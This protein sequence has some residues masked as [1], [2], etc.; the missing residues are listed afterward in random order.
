MLTLQQMI[1][2]VITDADGSAKEKLAAEAEKKEEKRTKEQIERQ[3]DREEAQQGGGSPDGYAEKTASAYVESLAAAVEEVNQALFP[4]LAMPMSEA[5]SSVG[6]G[7]GPGATST[8]LESPVP[9][10]Q[11][12]GSGQ[13]RT[14]QIPMSPPMESKGSGGND[15][16]PANAMATNAEMMHGE[17]PE[18]GVL[19]QGSVAEYL[20][21]IAKEAKGGANQSAFRRA[22]RTVGN[23]GR[24]DSGGLLQSS[25]GRIPGVSG[26]AGSDL[27]DEAVRRGIKRTVGGTAVLGTLGTAAAARK[28][29]GGKVL[30]PVGIEDRSKA[31]KDK[32]AEDRI[33]P[34][35]ISAPKSSALPEDAPSTMKRPAEV[36]SQEKW[37][38]NNE[39]PVSMGKSD[40]KGV[41]K[42]RMGEV[43]SE[44]A[45]SAS[46]D[47]VLDNALGA[48]TVDQAKAKIA[49]MRAYLSKI[50]SEG[51]T[52]GSETGTCSYCRLMKSAADS[53]ESSSDDKKKRQEKGSEKTSMGGTA[54]PPTVQP[55]SPGGAM[56]GM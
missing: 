2:Q 13:A 9:G 11:P 18:D 17:Q 36:T 37:L 54:V 3:A 1:E 29:A 44:P 48:G 30:T 6:P 52:C 46:T 22:M 39:A 26:E 43:L 14:G 7:K 8:N 21:G 33:N 20:Q 50:A 12:E 25:A 53:S 41:P 5:S 19:K 45:Q 28:A 15:K 51:C 56:G 35:Q 40:A 10:E 27:I 32:S 38:Q 16:A 31:G 34:A 4:K 24:N 47:T 49:E 55:S 42:K 23:I